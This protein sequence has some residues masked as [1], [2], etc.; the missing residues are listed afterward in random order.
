MGMYFG[1]NQ[2]LQRWESLIRNTELFPLTYSYEKTVIMQGGVILI[3]ERRLFL[4]IKVTFGEI[5]ELPPLDPLL[6]QGK[7]LT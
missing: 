4:F 2:E 7:Y 6:N 1:T 3:H 5:M